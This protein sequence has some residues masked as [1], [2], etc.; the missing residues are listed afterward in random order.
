MASASER[1][2]IAS[3]VLLVVIIVISTQM[4]PFPP[5]KENDENLLTW[6]D[7]QIQ[8]GTSRDNITLGEGFTAT[9]YMVNNRSRD[10]RMEPITS[11]TIEGG[12]NGT[13]GAGTSIDW[14]YASDYVM[15]LPANS[16]KKLIDKHFIPE[17][18]GEFIIT[19]LGVSKT[20]HVL[21]NESDIAEIIRL[22]LNIALVDKEIPDYHL[23]KDK[24]NIILCTE[25]LVEGLMPEMDIVNLVIL[26]LDDIQSKADR[27]GDFLY[28]RFTKL[29]MHTDGMGATVHLDNMW[30][31]RRG[32]PYA[33]LSGGGLNISFIKESGIWNG[34]IQAIWIS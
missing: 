19:S 6:R 5:F 4:Y 20:I 31:S 14:M 21:Y 22:S 11:C 2:L 16:R 1:I 30:M 13:N 32:S 15:A 28:L 25:N 34:K 18:A 27:E 26:D 8:I 9:V 12:I 3:G 7:M 10:I 17:Q 29:D 24:E 33:Y 23:I